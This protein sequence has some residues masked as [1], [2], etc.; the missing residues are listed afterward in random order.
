MK[1]RVTLPAKDYK[2]YIFDLGGTLID[3]M[4]IHYQSWREV[5]RRNSVAEDIFLEEEFYSFAGMPTKEVVDYM[6]ETYGC[7]MNAEAVE[8]MEDEIYK[9]LTEKNGLQAVKEVEDFIRSLPK[10]TPMAIATGCIRAG[11]KR[12]IKAAGLDGLIEILVTPEDVKR[13]KPAPDMF[14]LAAEKMGVEPAE[15]LVFEDAPFGFEAA[16][17]AGMDYTVVDPPQ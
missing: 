8:I 4:P 7:G 17:R 13:G 11:A 16:K 14:L 6:N 9:E 15:C 2:G 3:S 1:S 12:A 10:N 5:L